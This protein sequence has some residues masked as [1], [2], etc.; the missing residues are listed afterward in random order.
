MQQKNRAEKVFFRLS[1]VWLGMAAAIISFLLFSIPDIEI[2]ELAT[3]DHRFRTRAEL[4]PADTNPNVIL[5]AIDDQSLEKVGQWPW[6]RSYHGRMIEIL[7]QAGA[8]A[9]VLDVILSEPSLDPEDDRAL[10]SA[11][12][13]SGN[14]HLP[15]YFKNLKTNSGFLQ[16]SDKVLPLRKFSLAAAGI[17]PI[18]VTP[19]RDGII[20]SMPLVIESEGRLYPTLGF[21]LALSYLG[22]SPESLILARGFLEAEI[23]GG[24]KL[25]VPVDKRGRMIINFAGNFD[26]FKA[27]PW[28]T[29]FLSYFKERSGEKPEVDLAQF[30]DKIVIIGSSASGVGDIRPS[31]VNPYF[32]GFA[33]HASVISN[34]LDRNFLVRPSRLTRF[35]ILALLGLAIGVIVRKER[36]RRGIIFSF[37]LLLIYAAAG[38]LLFNYNLWL[39]L[40]STSLTVFLTCLTGTL[41]N[42]LAE[43]K[44]KNFIR[45]TFQRYVAPEIVS[46]ILSDSEKINLGG[47]RKRVTV[48]FADLRG[49]TRLSENLPPEE[50]VNLLN[51]SFEVITGAIFKHKGTLDKFIGDCVMAVF[52]AP[53][54]LQNQE[55]MAVRTGLEIKDGIE[56]MAAH[57]S[58]K[59]GTKIGIGIGINTGEAVIG[60]IG[61]RERMDYTAIGDTVNLAQRLESLAGPGQLFI[62]ES[63]FEPVKDSITATAQTP[64]AVKGKSRPVAFYEVQGF[65]EFKLNNVEAGYGRA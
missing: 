20:R 31:P 48:L 56:R 23:P 63:T 33:F 22:V 62:S 43:R 54:P 12:S 19:D 36:M 52:G 39:D 53:R 4:T 30:R 59:L 51:E 29:V 35:L 26:R 32:P 34:V 65:K 64:M 57:W 61:S 58:E 38:F 3:L 55:L 46:E 16:G 11:L 49:F 50:V 14:V 47:I 6:P 40:A 2:F 24:G 13:E 1:G 37:L 9:V 5:L 15:F 42:F 45:S 7:H 25:K 8:R 17:W 18:N 41:Q 28:E 27:F 21:A 60:N 44:E 10:L